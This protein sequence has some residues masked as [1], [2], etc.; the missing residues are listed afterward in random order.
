MDG[1]LGS[2]LRSAGVAEEAVGVHIDREVIAHL[3]T[4]RAA[5]G[6]TVVIAA[7]PTETLAR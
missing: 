4:H 6:D 1:A 3:L 2:Y 7:L 5:D